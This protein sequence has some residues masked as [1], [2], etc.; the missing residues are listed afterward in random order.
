MKLKFPP[1]T[2]GTIPEID[3]K[4]RQIVIIGAN[5][6]GKS[7][8]AN[9]LAADLGPRAYRL[10]ALEGLYGNRR[11]VIPADDETGSVGMLYNRLKP[12]ENASEQSQ[13][14]LSELQQLMSM[15]MHDE[16][17]N[18]LSYKL[19]HAEK[20]DAELRPTK[21]DSVISLWQEVFPGNRILIESGRFLFSR[22]QRDDSYSALKLSDG[23]QAV[24]YYIAAVLYAPRGA[25]IFINSPEIFLHPTI[26]QQLWNRIEAL[27]P[28][29]SFIYTTHDLDFA[30]SREGA[31]V[32][33]VRDFDASTMSW[34]YSEVENR[35]GI[36][37]EI[38]KAVIGARKPVL[39]IEGDGVHSIDSKLYPLIFKEYTVKSLGSCNKVIEATRTFNDL[40]SFHH[41]DSCGIVD[42]DRRDAHEVEYLR[43]KRVMVPEVAEIEN[44]LMLEEVIKAVAARHGADPAKVFSK[45]SNAVIAMFDHDLKSQALMHT[46]HRVK[47]TV[48]YRIDGKFNSIALFER[49]IAGLVDEIAP[50]RIYEEIC[51]KFRGYVRDGDYLSVLKVYNQK[52]MLPGSNVASLCG[53]RNKEEYIADIIDILRRD[54]PGADMIRRAVRRCLNI[55]SQQDTPGDSQKPI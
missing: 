52:S 48:E 53:L 41:L 19:A 13:G 15:L 17:L 21:L 12:F 33:W 6:A 27:R 54:L 50:R 25:A 14:R 34:D 42:R 22:K 8:F 4:G 32:I 9:R 30:S 31:Q 16:M 51:R 29:C 23:E 24:I 2:D 18:L 5:G 49:H 38:Y 1:R 3:T 35:G 20:R 45:V 47:R 44:I 55:P 36:S 40:N 28:D 26:M 37:D 10:S 46:R 39:F 43:G 11:D 7:R